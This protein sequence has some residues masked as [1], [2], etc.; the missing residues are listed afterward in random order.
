M[1]TP[2]GPPLNPVKFKEY[3]QNNTPQVFLHD[4]INWEC[5]PTDILTIADLI[6]N[7]IGNDE[8]AIPLY[9]HA[10]KALKNNPGIISPDTNI[11]GAYANLGASLIRLEKYSEAI[12]ALNIA[13][14]MDNFDPSVKFHLAIGYFNLNEINRSF[15]CLKE[16]FDLP[17]SRVRERIPETY[18]DKACRL[19][20][21]IKSN[22][23]DL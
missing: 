1:K 17:D 22:F 8:Y 18:Y 23:K 15:Y 20:D 6:V 9:Y 13:N 2:F 19:Y 21:Y 12:K 10:L 3:I 7:F 5:D 16:L 14:E 11:Q 4:S